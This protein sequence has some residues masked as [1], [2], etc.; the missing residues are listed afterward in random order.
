MKTSP[1]KWRSFCI[2]LSVL[3]QQLVLNMFHHNRRY[4]AHRL[5]YLDFPVVTSKNPLNFQNMWTGSW[6]GKLCCHK[7]WY[8]FWDTMRV[9]P[10]VCKKLWLNHPPTNTG[11]NSVWYNNALL[12]A[13]IRHKIRHLLRNKDLLA[14]RLWTPG[15]LIFLLILRSLL[16]VPE[17]GYIMVVR[18]YCV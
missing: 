16:C 4:K 14:N 5:I 3:K 11:D 6:F 8:P 17:A 13:Y 9:I 12:S 2:G 7:L 18:S 15:Y 1:T 10:V